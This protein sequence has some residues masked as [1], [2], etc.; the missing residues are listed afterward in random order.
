MEPLPHAPPQHTSPNLDPVP[1]DPDALF[2][3]APFTNF[4]NSH[5]HGPEGLTYAILAV[6]HDWFL[7][8]S[9][10]KSLTN[11]APGVLTYPVQLEPPRGWCH[12]KKKDIKERGYDG[13]PDGQEPRL[14]CTFCRR[15][16][17]GVNAKS[18]WRR[19]VYEK[20]KIAMANRRDGNERAAVRGRQANSKS[21]HFNAL[22]PRL[23]CCV[24]RREQDT[25]EPERGYN[26]PDD[27]SV[28]WS[29]HRPLSDRDWGWRVYASAC[30]ASYSARRVPWPVGPRNVIR[31]CS[32]WRTRAHR[33]ATSDAPRL[34]VT[35]ALWIPYAGWRPC[36]GHSSGGTHF[37]PRS[38]GNPRVSLRPAA[39]PL[40]P[41]FTSKAAV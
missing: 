2:I 17:A 28:T 23:I 34:G 37:Y 10:F 38:S 15:T 35:Q 7:D 18:M 31:T 9:D 6:N 26:G 1:G 25:E 33:H 16:Y 12:M 41:P 32:S 39:N 19:H 13:W 5:L 14:R 36:I 27:P 3:R 8:P 24:C 4:P 11:D 21:L 29:R 22:T 30:G 40:L 20:H